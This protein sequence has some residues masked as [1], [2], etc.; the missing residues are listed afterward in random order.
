M[1]IKGYKIQFKWQEKA[2][3]WWNERT[4]A[5]WPI[6]FPTS[7]QART[8]VDSLPDPFV[9]LRGKRKLSM[10]IVPVYA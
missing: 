6:L 7:E 4:L 10:S 1:T 9:N 8:L 5:H 3:D 2:G